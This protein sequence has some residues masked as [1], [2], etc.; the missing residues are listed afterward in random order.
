MQ[1]SMLC[2]YHQAT[3]DRDD[4]YVLPVTCLSMLLEAAV[5]I[6]SIN[7]SKILKAWNATKSKKASSE[8]R[9]LEG[10]DTA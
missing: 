6:G 9:A 3:A 1:L 8:H 7:D 5:K 4:K 2:G 10:Q